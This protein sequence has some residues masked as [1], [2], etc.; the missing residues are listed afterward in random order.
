[1]QS[2]ISDEVIIENYL[3]ISKIPFL[4]LLL[5]LNGFWKIYSH[6]F[7]IASSRAHV[8]TCSNANNIQLTSPINGE[9]TDS[10]IINQKYVLSPWSCLK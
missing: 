8:S 4:H 7:V 5:I 6:S 10:N 3:K 9:N 1:M 2:L